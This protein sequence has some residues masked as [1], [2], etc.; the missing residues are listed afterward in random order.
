MDA[1]D[2]V[3]NSS[4]SKVQHCSGGSKRYT[5]FVVHILIVENKHCYV[6]TFVCGVI[7]RPMYC[8]FLS[9][10]MH[11]SNIERQRDVFDVCLTR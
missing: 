5:R 6:I 4:T 9:T 1:F 10:H 7:E 2:R 8:A 3:A 11:V